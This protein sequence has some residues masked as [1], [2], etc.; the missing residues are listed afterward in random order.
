[1]NILTDNDWQFLNRLIFD[2][3]ST[4]DLDK[5]RIHVLEMLKMIIPC[6]KATFYLADPTGKHRF[7]LPVG[8]G[9]TEQ[10]LTR[11]DN[12]F[13][14][15]DPLCWAF[16]SA[17]NEVYRHTDLYPPGVRDELPFYKKAY[18][19]LNIYY[20]AI[21]S[22]SHDNI[23]VGAVSLYRPKDSHDFSDREVKILD[24]LKN[25]LA[26]RLF[27][28]MGQE[29]RISYKKQRERRLN[30]YMNRY[31]LTHRELEILTL[32]VHGEQNQSI[33]EKLFITQSTLKKHIYNIYKKMDIKNRVELFKLFAP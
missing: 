13:E 30:D 11:Y 29:N 3:Y 28:E 24:T 12:E 15:L 1:M 26:L 20:T 16:S 8:F 10:Q 25:H 9:F 2:I 31:D 32:L 4:A 6:D 22:L 23:F 7:I 27:Q 17:Q 33:C 19:D 18:F 5:I 21:L 14:D